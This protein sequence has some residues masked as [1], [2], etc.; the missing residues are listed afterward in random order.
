MSDAAKLAIAGAAMLTLAP[1]VLGVLAVA[2]LDP[3]GA[4]ALCA[5]ATVSGVPATASGMPASVGGWPA[6]GSWSSTQVANA[7]TI[8]TVGAR[9][10]VP[11]WGWVVA[12]ATAM[13]ESS[14]YNLGNLG[15]HNDHDSLGLF[16]QRPSQGWGTPE[17]IMNPVYAATKFYEHLLRVPNWQSL[18]LTEAAQRVQRSG[19]PGA[20]QKWQPEAQHLVDVI[21]ARLGITQSCGATAGGWVLP[22]PAGS[23]GLSSP[24]GPRW[25]GFHYGQDL[26][27]P[28][29]T[30]IFA[31]AA[32]TVIDAGCTSPR[33][34]IPGSTQM[35]GC[36][37]RV[38]Q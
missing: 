22:L 1:C 32:G 36:G 15:A 28:T 8:V 37:W 25:G 17:Q 5:P 12:I 6:D 34:D 29:G 24:F 38:W 16:Q 30:P 19:F 14:L 27:A 26:M 4:S 10:G 11:R 9:M 20:Y 7:A 2:V 23:Y 33:C 18:P 35:P 21:T 31:A 13:Q 3:A